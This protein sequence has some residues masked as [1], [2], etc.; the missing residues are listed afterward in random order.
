MVLTLA[1]TL[2]TLHTLDQVLDQR[3]TLIILVLQVD[4]VAEVEAD[5]IRLIHILVQ[6]TADQVLDQAQV[7]VQVLDQALVAE[8]AHLHLSKRAHFLDQVALEVLVVT[9]VLVLDQVLDQVATAQVTT[10]LTLQC[11]LMA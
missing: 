1:H 9:P 11:V 6:V 3:V 5:H 7:L 10:Q 8:V 2:H 4:Q